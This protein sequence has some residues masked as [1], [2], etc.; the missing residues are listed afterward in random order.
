[1]LYLKLVVIVRVLEAVGE[2][3]LSAW[4]GDGVEGDPSVDTKWAW[5]L[6]NF[7]QR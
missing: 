6:K 1:M 3:K 5:S 7:F 2:G 4:R